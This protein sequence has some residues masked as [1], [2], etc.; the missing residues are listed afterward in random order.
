MEQR[1]LIWILILGI[2]NPVNPFSKRIHRIKKPGFG[3]A[4]RSAKSVLRSKIRQYF[5]FTERNT[6][7]TALSEPLMSAVCVT[8]FPAKQDEVMSFV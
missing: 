6:P 8:T 3:F 5:G 2:S 4:E 7:L 1:R